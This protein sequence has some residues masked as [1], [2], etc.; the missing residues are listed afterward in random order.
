MTMFSYPNGGAE[1]YYT[2][3]IQQLVRGAGYAAASTSSNRIATAG[4]RP[5]RP[6][7]AARGGERLEDLVYELERARWRR[8]RPDA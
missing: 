3:A 1:V 7:A 2:P 4:E 8:R 6:G 5:L